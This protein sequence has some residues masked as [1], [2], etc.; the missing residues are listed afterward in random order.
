M[1]YCTFCGKPLASGTIRH[2]EFIDC[3]LLCFQNRGEIMK[4]KQKPV[5]A[6]DAIA[7]DDPARESVAAMKVTKTPPPDWAD[8]TARGWAAQ[9]LKQAQT[10][11]WPELA[12]AYA[13]AR[14]CLKTQG[15]T[16][17]EA[18]PLIIATLYERP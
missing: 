16:Q 5:A 2:N 7:Q 15:F 17:A 10:M 9:T 1:N 18:L 8:D 4:D 6:M 13:Y 14:D 11:R 12:A 3:H